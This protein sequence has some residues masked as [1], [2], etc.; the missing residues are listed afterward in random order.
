MLDIKKFTLASLTIMSFSASAEVSMNLGVTSNYMWR[1][2]TQSND[3]AA[4]SGGIDYTNDNGLYAGVWTSNVDFGAGS[5]SE[6]DLY[7][8][9]ASSINSIDYDIGYVTYTYPVSGFEDSDYREVSLKTSYKSLTLGVALT[10]S[11]DID[12][13]QAF[14]TGD[15]YTHASYSF[16][17]PQ[18]YSLTLTGGVYTF[19][20]NE[21]IF[22]DNDYNHIQIDINKSD[23]TF[24]VSKAAEESGSD[25]LKVFAGWTKLF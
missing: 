16:K 4:I 23:F 25:N 20:E 2:V 11:S 12:D 9:Y 17:L 19:D 24:S 21:S 18:E 6:V 13:N 8:G 5:G 22:G 10:V 7:V 14:S 15:I 3:S 1:G